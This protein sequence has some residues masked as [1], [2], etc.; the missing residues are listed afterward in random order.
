MMRIVK[1][2]S[3]LGPNRWSKEPVAEYYIELGIDTVRT[4]LELSII[5][6]DLHRLSGVEAASFAPICLAKHTYLLPFEYEELD[7]LTE[8]VR[9]SNAASGRDSCR[10]I[11]GGFNRASQAG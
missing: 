10:A 1:I 6:S 2:H 9:D 5:A 7:L 3:F 8:C 4:A 11:R